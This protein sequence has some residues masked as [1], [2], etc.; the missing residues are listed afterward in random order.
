M[1][2]GEA[3]NEAALCEYYKVNTFQDGMTWLIFLITL[4]QSLT[5]LNSPSQPEIHIARQLPSNL[6]LLIKKR[7]NMHG[8]TITSNVK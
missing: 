3:H 5:H 4:P 7:A 2:G 8:S 6:G 1:G